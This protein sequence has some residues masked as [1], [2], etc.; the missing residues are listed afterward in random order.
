[1]KVV[2]LSLKGTK[3]IFPETFYDDRGF[4]LEYYQKERYEKVGISSYF[5]QD[6]HSFS[7]KDVIRGMHFQRPCQR[8]CEQEV[9]EQKKCRQEKLVSVIQGAIYDVIVDLRVGSPT[10]K[11]WEAVLL[12]GNTHK[13]LFIPSGCAH[14]FCVLS[15]EAHLLYKVTT[16]Y[17]PSREEGLAYNDPEI[18]IQWP[19]SHPILSLKDQQNPLFCELEL[20]L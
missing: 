1:M 19:I 8:S 2:E 13:Q 7:R 6:N 20:A 15:E 11:Q 5:V 9:C 12:E 18:G 14:G 16:Y 17:D 10:F 4:F 3:V